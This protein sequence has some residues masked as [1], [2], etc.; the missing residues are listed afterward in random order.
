MRE[1]VQM[2]FD[3]SVEPPNEKGYS[4]VVTYGSSFQVLN[5]KRLKGAGKIVLSCR[6]FQT[7]SFG[8]AQTVYVPNGLLSLEP[9]KKA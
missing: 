1:D 4:H 8:R 6:S 9:S 7:V 5:E 3:G 2:V